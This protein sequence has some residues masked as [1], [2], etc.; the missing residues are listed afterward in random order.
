MYITE[1]GI[2][3]H[4][5]I[6]VNCNFSHFRFLKTLNMTCIPNMLSSL[7]HLANTK[8]KLCISWKQEV[9]NRRLLL[10]HFTSEYFN[11]CS[12]SCSQLQYK[13][14]SSYWKGFI[15][16]PSIV[17]V[18]YAFP[19]NQVQVFEEYLMFGFNDLVGT[20]GGHSGLF[21]GFSFYGFLAQ[22]IAYFQ[23]HL[24]QL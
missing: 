24:N 13:G 23:N 6:S 17:R 21:I 12:P 1:V 8:I 14:E 7:E 22:I 19:S 9:K 15:K 4:F 18:L 3:N 10:K 11:S 16:E 2:N 5:I 20:I